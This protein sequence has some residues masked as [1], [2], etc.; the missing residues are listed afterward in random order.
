MNTGSIAGFVAGGINTAGNAT[1]VID[2]TPF[3]AGGQ[4]STSVGNIVQAIG[5]RRSSGMSSKTHG[6]VAGGYH[7]SVGSTARLERFPF[8]TSSG[9]TDIGN[10]A[11][12][13]SIST[14]GHVY[15][16]GQIGFSSSGFTGG[17]SSIGRTEIERIQFVTQQPA[18]VVG[19]MATSRADCGSVSSHAHGYFISGSTNS[20]QPSFLT[21]VVLRFPFSGQIGDIANRVDANMQGWGA[22]PWTTIPSAGNMSRNGYQTATAGIIAGGTSPSGSP[23]QKSVYKFT[24]AADTTYN[25]VGDIDISNPVTGIVGRG[26]P[27]IPFQSTEYGYAVGVGEGGPSPVVQTWIMKFPFAA[28]LAHQYIGD[29]TASHNNGSGH[30]F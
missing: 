25:F 24:W 26:Y 9:A 2:R 18:F 10:L 7:G 17:P 4:N 11:R 6:F 21:D 29:T 22:G 27:S 5:L 8:T 15:A 14:I 12:G 30:H 19:G 13:S 20:P 1:S 3:A 16:S 28:E 23:W